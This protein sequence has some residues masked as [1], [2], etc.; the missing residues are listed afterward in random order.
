[1]LGWGSMAGGEDRQAAEARA[2]QASP[3]FSSPRTHT[4]HPL[5]HTPSLGKSHPRT[6]DTPSFPTQMGESRF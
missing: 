3:E 6:R 1:M 2:G 5:T 4:Q